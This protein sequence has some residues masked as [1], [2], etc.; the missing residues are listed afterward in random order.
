MVAF[1]SVE[2]LLPVTPSTVTV[3]VGAGVGASV[4]EGDGVVGR[5]SVKVSR[6]GEAA[7]A[8]GNAGSVG[9]VTS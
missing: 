1:G 9:A 7:S 8:A 2:G 6:P 3:T 4:V 5:G